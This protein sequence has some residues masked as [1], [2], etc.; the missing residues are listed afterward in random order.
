ML[1]ARLQMLVTTNKSNA[2]FKETEEPVF[3][4]LIT[5]LGERNEVIYKNYHIF[6]YVSS[7][8][9]KLRIKEFEDYIKKACNEVDEIISQY[10]NSDNVEYRR[11]IAQALNSIGQVLDTQNHHKLIE[12]MLVMDLVNDRLL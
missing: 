5:L 9:N 2:G 12:D 4:F 3:R 6:G 8:D 10:K 7:G 1:P 11:H